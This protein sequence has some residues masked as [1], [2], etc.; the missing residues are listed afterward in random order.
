MQFIFIYAIYLY[1]HPLQDNELRIVGNFIEYAFFIIIYIFFILQ[2]LIQR[3]HVIF[4]LLLSYYVDSLCS[5]IDTSYDIHVPSL[6]YQ[7]AFFCLSGVHTNKLLTSSHG[8]GSADCYSIC[9]PQCSGTYQLWRSVYPNHRLKSRFFIAFLG[10]LG[11]E[12]ETLKPVVFPSLPMPA[13]NVMAIDKPPVIRF[14]AGLA[15]SL[16]VLPPAATGFY[17]L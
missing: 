2:V 17:N 10:H 7:C 6:S 3:L 13:S 11:K 12:A 1:N 16:T 5:P 9:S 8:P 15:S 4:Q 14:L